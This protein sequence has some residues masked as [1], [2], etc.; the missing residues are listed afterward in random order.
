VF[1]HI[2]GEVTIQKKSIVAILDME[3]S[4]LSKGTKN[5]LKTSEKVGN[6]INVSEKLPRSFVVIEKNKKKFVYISPISSMTLLKR[7]KK[8]I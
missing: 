7:L 3:T 8:I 1:L 6:I 2:G 4:T 5:Y